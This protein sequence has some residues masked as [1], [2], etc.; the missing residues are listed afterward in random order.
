MPAQLGAERGLRRRHPGAEERMAA[1][2]DQRFG[3]E[4]S[5]CFGD[6]VGELHVVDETLAAQLVAEALQQHPGC[7]LSVERHAFVVHQRDAVAVA[8]EGDA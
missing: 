8:V 2:F 3:A 4:L 1:A 5:R 7:F 6:P